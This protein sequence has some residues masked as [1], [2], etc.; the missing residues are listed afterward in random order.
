MVSEVQCHT[1]P[2]VVYLKPSDVCESNVLVDMDG[3]SF[4]VLMYAQIERQTER[5]VRDL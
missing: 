4:Q 2:K 5:D 3:Q 1:I